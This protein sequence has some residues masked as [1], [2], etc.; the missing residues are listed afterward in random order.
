MADARS[1]WNGLPDSQRRSAVQDRAP[2]D[3]VVF[4]CVIS[5]KTKSRY[6]EAD[7]GDGNWRTVSLAPKGWKL[8][9]IEREQ[10]IE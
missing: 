1:I 9:M 7:E 3:G 6:I 10:S 8:T 4:R 2:V 5:G